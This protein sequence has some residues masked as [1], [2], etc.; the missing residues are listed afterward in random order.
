MGKIDHK[1]TQLAEIVNSFAPV[2]KELK[3]AYDAAQQQAEADMSEGEINDEESPQHETLNDAVSNALTVK[4][5]EIDDLVQE[6]TENETTAAGLPDKIAVVLE[7][8]LASGFNE[9]ALNKRKEKIHRPANCKLLQ[10]TKVNSEIWDVAKKA[11]RSMDA[12]LQ[13]LQE[14]LVKGLSPT[15]RLAGIVGESLGKPTAERI[16]IPPEDLWEGLSNFVLLI[17][18]ANHDLN[19]CSNKQPVE[20][21][22]FAN[23]LA[24]R[25]KTVKESKKASQQLTV[26]KRKREEPHSRGFHPSR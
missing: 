21:E 4:S 24:E 20:L 16:V 3:S 9:Q 12:L 17:A 11:T 23:D 15:A 18:S 2:V 8:I 7:S 25:L 19:M 14:A 26:Q 5:N 6:V 10:V 1:L 13:K 22:L